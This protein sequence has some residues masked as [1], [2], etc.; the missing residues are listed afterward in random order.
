MDL[1]EGLDDPP[2]PQDAHVSAAE[3]PSGA[4]QQ[5][6]HA[7]LQCAP[8][9]R[10]SALPLLPELHEAL[11][12]GQLDLG[13]LGQLLPVLRDEAADVY[14]Q[15]E[16][17]YRPVFP[18][19]AELV[20]SQRTYVRV[21]RAL[22]TG[23]PLDELLTREQAML[24]AMTRPQAPRADPARWPREL[25]PHADRH[26]QLHTAVDAID[27]HIVRQAHRLAPTV[28]ALVGPVVAAAL[29]SH[30]GSVRELAQVPACNLAAIGA[31]RHAAH[32]R[33]TDASGVRLRG[34]VWDTPLV[35][36]QPPAL[37][38]Q[39]LR[40][41]CARLALAARVDASAPDPA[42]AA[43]WRADILAR[44]AARA[45][46]PA[47]AAAAPLPVPADAKPRRRAGRRFRAHRSKFRLSAARQLQNRAAFG[48]P[49]RTAVDGFGEE[50]G[51]GL[52]GAPAAPPPR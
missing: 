31:P 46:P 23:A 51:L 20:P 44:I 52:S 38:R 29:L 18:E 12:A 2:S 19:L 35:Q 10:P 3:A 14:R 21:L 22:E 30:A 43:R 16:A 25:A 37:Q 4:L 45:A 47:P 15:L 9:S 39:A 32:A 5:R 6:L 26:E 48:V 34:H 40:M 13:T 28:T 7:L 17:R 27:A 1:L 49:E 41:L 42:L 11:A 36:E 24:V 50:I 8:R 33:R